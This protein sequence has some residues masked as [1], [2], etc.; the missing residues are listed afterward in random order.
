[1]IWVDRAVGRPSHIRPHFLVLLLS[2]MIY[3][4]RLST[5]STFSTCSH[6]VPYVVGH[7]N[8][9]VLSMLRY[10]CLYASLCLLV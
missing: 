5:L 2:V 6:G 1:M 8:S 10:D 3:G 4:T 9:A 7:I